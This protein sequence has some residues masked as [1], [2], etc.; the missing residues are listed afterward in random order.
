MLTLEMLLELPVLGVLDCYTHQQPD[1]Q[2]KIAHTLV[3]HDSRFWDM[4]L[5]FARFSA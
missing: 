4:F 5:D 2:Y 3:S 1:I